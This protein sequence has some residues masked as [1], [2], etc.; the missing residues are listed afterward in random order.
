MEQMSNWEIIINYLSNNQG[1]IA[2]INLLATIL[3]FGGILFITIKYAKSTE[4]LA[5]K[6]SE[7]LELTRK[8]ER[9]L[10]KFLI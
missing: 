7:S 10:L 1:L 3:I 9:N 5:T 4:K 8:K 6:T 2:F